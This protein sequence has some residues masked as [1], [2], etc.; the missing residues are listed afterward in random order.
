M[1]IARTGQSIC[2]N[3][4]HRSRTDLPGGGSVWYLVQPQA[5]RHHLLGLGKFQDTRRFLMTYPRHVSS[6]LP[7]SLKPA[8]ATITQKKLEIFSTYLRAPF[9]CVSLGRGVV[10][11]R[12]SGGTP[13]LPCIY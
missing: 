13:E 7:L 11:F 5:H 1:L 6:R 4:S 10:G 12:I 8:M 2:S 9:R 3:S